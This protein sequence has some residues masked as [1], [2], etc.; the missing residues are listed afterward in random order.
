MDH[1]VASGIA[2]SE[3]VQ[4]G[5]KKGMQPPMPGIVRRAPAAGVGVRRHSL[6]LHGR[7]HLG[8]NDD[9]DPA[10]WPAGPLPFGRGGPAFHGNLPLITGQSVVAGSR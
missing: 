6:W 2:R 1:R 5:D 7:R 3:T 8:L 9:D 10:C 4:T